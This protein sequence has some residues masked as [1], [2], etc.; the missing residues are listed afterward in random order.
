MS[1]LHTGIMRLGAR[2]APRVSRS[3]FQS[4]RMRLVSSFHA[5]ADG[6][7]KDQPEKDDVAE[8]EEEIEDD[9][10]DE[11]VMEVSHVGLFEDTKKPREIVEDL[12]RHIVGQSAA[13]R[14]VAIALRNRW[15]RMKLDGDLREEVQ[16]KNILMIG[17]TGV[18]KTEIARRLATI[19]QSPFI[20]VEATKFTE[21]GFHGRDVDKI[22]SDLV[23]ISM[24]LT[25]KLRMEVLGKQVKI[26]A[27]KEI[28]DALTGKSSKETRRSFEELLRS[29]QL[30][31]H[32]ISISVPVDRNPLAGGQPIAID[33]GQGAV[34]M[35]QIVTQIG[36]M[37]G[38]GKR[39]KRKMPISEAR[40]LL[41][42]VEME[43]M[44]DLTDL[45]R[46]AIRHVEENGIV[47]IDEIDMI[48]A[49]VSI[50]G[51]H[52]TSFDQWKKIPLHTFR[53]CICGSSIS[54]ATYLVNLIYEHNAILFHVTNC[55]SI[56]ISEI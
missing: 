15:R 10:E 48:G 35:N 29:G 49:H 51:I 44:L 1:L 13:K 34:H 37:I 55:F 30:D 31:S 39:E 24:N 14:A 5:S 46:E 32:N 25:K 50:F 6:E 33:A 19:S 11:E 47:F 17:P 53:T 16:P 28:L 54:R 3:H 21:V 23:E 8:I 41:E 27:E 56:K 20:K 43:K 2:L 22:I 26:A 42:D 9:I 12:E 7:K 18:G 38:G 4:P 52:N 45:N 36:K 40:P